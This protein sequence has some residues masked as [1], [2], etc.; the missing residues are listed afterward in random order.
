MKLKTALA[1]GFTALLGLGVNNTQA[2]EVTLKAVSFLPLTASFGWPF[3][4]F[5]DQANEQCAGSVKINVLPPGSI[6]AFEQPNALKTG[7]VDMMSGPPNYYKGTLVE[8]DAPVLSN[9]STAEQ[10]SNGAQAYLN[11]L[12]N[13]KLNAQYLTAFGNDIP[14]HIYTSKPMVD[15]RMDGFTMRTAP[16]YHAFFE[17]LGARVVAMPPPDIYTALERGTVDGFGWPLWGVSD[18]GWDKVAKHRYDP[19]FYSANVNILV[20]LDK[21]NSL[22]QE[23]Q[24]CLTNTAIWLEEQWPSWKAEQDAKEEAKQKEAGI[25]VTDMGAAHK[26]TAHDLYWA[27]LEKASPNAIKELKTLLVK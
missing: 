23:Q 27:D 13:E 2:D 26:Q 6:K 20:N 10:R 21:W 1:A 18:F 16:I 15:G 24:D 12:H 19:G 5:V 22:D 3:A 4:R 17:S 8:G 14:F 7:V 11:K 25:E 9:L